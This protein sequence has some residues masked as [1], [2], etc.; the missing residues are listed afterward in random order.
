MAI[1]LRDN[2]AWVSGAN[3]ITPVIGAAQV[4]G[5]MMLLFV[6]GKPFDAG[7][8]APGGWASLGSAASG[9]TAAGVD[10]GS[11]KAEVFWKE[12]VSD[13]ETNPL[14]TETTPVW[15]VAAAQVCVFSKGAGETWVTPV[16][17]FGGDETNG[18]G[19]SVTF[20]SNPGG[21]A[22]DYVYLA[23]G[24]NTDAMGPLLT[25][26]SFVWTG[27]TFGTPDAANEGESTLGGDIA[28]HS[29]TNSVS[30]GTSSAA[31]T[32]T[33]TGTLS[34]GAD[35][36]EAV[37]VRLRVSAGAATSLIYPPNPLQHILTR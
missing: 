5:D 30:S 23:C 6:T 11:M 17:A 15:N 7:W 26:L 21:A 35:R 24:I 32:T 1:A 28:V 34:G 8:T 14:V 10:T 13:T 25:D 22:G 33:G 16:I 18:S 20:G 27:I 19:I 12:A 3:S 2:G 4:T 29:I 37:F 36:L 9:S 31:P